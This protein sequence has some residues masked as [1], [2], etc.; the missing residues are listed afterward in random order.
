[1]GILYYYIFLVLGF[2]ISWIYI[3][4]RLEI[5]EK[6]LI[7]GCGQLGFKIGNALSKNFDVTG[8]KRKNITDGVQFKIF[9][10]DIFSERFIQTIQI[11]NPHYIVYATAADN[12]SEESY[13]NAYVN[14]LSISIKAAMACCNIKHF[15]FISSTRVYGQKSDENLSEFTLPIPSDFGGIALL[16]GE[17]ILRNSTVP[18]TI[19]RL[20]GIY[21][22]N[23]RSMLK[24]ATTP[25]LWPV[26]NRWTN[27]IHED[28][29]VRFLSFLL[30]SRNGETSL[31]PLYLL[32]DNSPATVYEVLNWI[33]SKLNFPEHPINAK[34]G[35]VGKKLISKII[36]ELNFYFK[37]SD[38]QKG[39]TSI[40]NEH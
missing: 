3:Q 28:D 32:T 2:L 5:K 12:Q 38:Y 40:I 37:Y 39:Y 31:E 6:L 17:T 23:R 20:S 15:F 7:V 13:Q 35:L 8:I 36:P 34:G 26:N 16:E 10:L 4:D 14:G 25:E 29:A 27:R 11:I 22:N 9:E 21:G 33:R 24:L 18:S 19:L 1:M 30:D